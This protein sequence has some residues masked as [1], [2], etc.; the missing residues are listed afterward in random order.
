MNKLLITTAALTTAIAATAAPRPAYDTGSTEFYYSKAQ[1]GYTWS[2]IAAD[3]GQTEVAG[4][5]T[6][7]VGAS[8]PVNELV[9]V[10][11]GYQRASI[12][13]TIAS[14]DNN[15]ISITTDSTTQTFTIGGGARFPIAMDVDF[16]V[17]ASY[18]WQNNETQSVAG[19][20]ILA[21]NQSSTNFAAFNAGLLM[22]LPDTGLYTA[23]NF[24]LGLLEK[25]QTNIGAEVGFRPSD[26]FSV[27]ATGKFDTDFTTTTLGVVGNLHF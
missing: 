17:G 1:V 26:Q 21:T 10:N 6:L 12:D 9:F 5:E 8:Y 18:N 14:I 27:A 7:V 23:A 22:T 3:D 24:E 13:N 2:Q 11:G 19:S 16:N 4:P 20:T 25:T 15:L